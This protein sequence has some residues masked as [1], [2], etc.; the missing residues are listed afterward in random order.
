MRSSWSWNI[1]LFGYGG[2][3]NYH[4]CTRFCN[5]DDDI[6]CVWDKGE[7]GM[8]SWL[9][10]WI[11]FSRVMWCRN[12]QLLRSRGCTPTKNVSEHILWRLYSELPQKRYINDDKKILCCD[13]MSVTW[14]FTPATLNFN[15]WH[16]VLYSL[17]FQGGKFSL[18]GHHLP[19]TCRAPS[20]VALNVNMT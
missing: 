12:V 1:L 2:S 7:D 9:A 4:L 17:F 16:L 10:N 11:I 8:Q 3:K 13:E 19:S 18:H 5:Y 20:L 6:V 14:A 15:C